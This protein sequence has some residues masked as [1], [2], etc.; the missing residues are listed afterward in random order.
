PASMAFDS[1]TPSQGTCSHASGTVTCELGTV[2]NGASATVQI[3][4]RP[5]TTGTIT[6]TA[7]VASELSDPTPGNNTASTPTTVNANADLSITMTDSPDPVGVNQ[8]LT[9]TLAVANAGPSTATSV[10]V[11]D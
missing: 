7:S 9:Y 1:A 6:N 10:T 2:A 4:V 11:L 5:Q 3:K 8:P